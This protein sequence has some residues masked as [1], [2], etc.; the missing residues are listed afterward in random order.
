MAVAG[1]LIVTGQCWTLAYRLPIDNGREHLVT[2]AYDNL[3]MGEPDKIRAMRH[4]SATCRNAKGPRRKYG[5]PRGCLDEMLD[6][7]NDCGWFAD[8]RRMNE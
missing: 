7:R 4:S 3:S 2:E 1:R 6:K 8:G 5:G